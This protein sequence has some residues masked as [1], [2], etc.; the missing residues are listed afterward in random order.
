MFLCGCSN[1]DKDDT[2]AGVL[3]LDS[4]SIFDGDGV[5]LSQD[6]TGW[7]LLPEVCTIKA[8][9]DG[10]A[11][12]AEFYTTPT[13]TETDSEKTLIGTA[14]IDGKADSVSLEWEP[15][16]FM[17]YI[18]VVLYNNAE[19]ISSEDGWLIKAISDV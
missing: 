13:G 18:S 14:N 12:K 11:T 19:S 5:E 8:D 3:A 15:S 9:Y 1:V 7:L 6:E 4:I 10:T 2:D 17:G 16:G